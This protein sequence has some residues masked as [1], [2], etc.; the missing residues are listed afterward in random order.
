MYLDL[1]SLDLISYDL[2]NLLNLVN[3]SQVEILSLAGHISPNPMY[4]YYNLMIGQ[5]HD[6]FQQQY[7]RFLPYQ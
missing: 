3:S 4:T 2:L 7:K 1:L 6:I 5:L